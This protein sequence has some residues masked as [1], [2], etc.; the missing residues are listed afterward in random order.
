MQLRNMTWPQIDQLSRQTPV[1]IPIAAVEQ[2]G[3]HLPLYTDS[4]LLGEVVRRAEEP[5]ANDILVAPLQWYGNSHHHMDFA[6]TLSAEPR[7]YL[8]LLVSLLD[9]FIAHGFER[10]FLI[11]GHG[12]NDVPG[13]QALFEV[14][15]KYRQRNDLLLLFS[16][17]WTLGCRPPESVPEL[18]QTEMGHACE[19]ETSMILRIAPELVGDYHQAE[20][21]EHGNPFLP[22][23]RAWITKDRSPPGHIGWPQLATADKG[24]ALLTMFSRDVTQLLQR[25]IDWDG[26][27]WDG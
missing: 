2:H 21:I 6:G 4:I 14:R 22:A 15:Q 9:N 17:Y 26:K 24:E 25:M 3:H 19:W 1:L 7:V 27:S 11:N 12:G 20:T 5:L 10:L 18:R 8:D 13:K 16:T 23:T